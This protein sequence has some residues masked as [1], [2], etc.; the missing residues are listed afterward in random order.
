MEDSKT[1]IDGGNI[2]YNII[3][4]FFCALISI[5]FLFSGIKD[6]LV[7]RYGF[8]IVLIA[9]GFVFVGL[10]IYAIVDML[11]R[12]KKEKAAQLPKEI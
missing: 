11:V 4:V 3:F 8:G 5:P 9:M 12:I 1:N 6:L 2:L 10:T 7:H